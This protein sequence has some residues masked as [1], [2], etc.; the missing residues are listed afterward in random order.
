[1]LTGDGD[2]LGNRRN[3]IAGP[4]HF[5]GIAYPNVFARHFIGIVQGRPADGDATDFH[6]LQERDWR[7]GPGSSDRDDDIMHNGDFLARRKFVGDGPSWTA[8]LHA[9]TTLPV[10]AVHLYH[11]TIDLIGQLVAHRFR[12]MVKRNHVID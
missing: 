11:H 2:P 8:R 10:S 9:Q 4:F 6:R 1:M 7:E 12:F 3:D 5:D